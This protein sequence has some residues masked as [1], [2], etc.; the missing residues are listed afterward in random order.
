MKP[1]DAVVA[2]V[3]EQGPGVVLIVDD[4]PENLAMLHEALDAAGYRVLVAT[5]G[6]MALDRVARLVPDVILL[7][8]LMPGMDGFETCRRL[9]ADALVAHVPVV[10]MT[11][12]S[13]TDHILAGF[14]AGGVDYLTKPIRPPEVLARIAAHVRNA[15]QM[16]SA[17]QAVDAAGH[18]MLS[19]DRLGRIRWQSP[20]A[21]E[22]LGA[23][24][25]ADGHLPPVALAWLAQGDAQALPVV[26]NGRR[27]SLS[28]LSSDSH[29]ATLLLRKL[30]SAPSPQ[31]LGA[32]YGLTGR[33]SE[34]LYWVACGKINRDV[35][36]ILGMSAR[37][38]D[39]H[40]QHVFEKLHVETRTAAVSMVLNQAAS[41]S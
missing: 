31:T 10:F 41:N 20:S 8:A 22:W 38:V 18:A 9:K 35:G 28:R 19:V 5:D 16:A 39:K 2:V 24:L 25:D 27:L 12:L 1:I 30:A 15:R 7:D 34:V 6:Q 11:G 21:R 37:T 13:D 23:Y 40:L 36:D 29:G 3:A 26:A 17:R 4:A 32:T 33:E 14:Q